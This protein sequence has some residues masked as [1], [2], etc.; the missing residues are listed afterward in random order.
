M[1][2]KMNN[3]V[4]TETTNQMFFIEKSSSRVE[5]KIDEKG[6]QIAYFQDGKCQQVNYRLLEGVRQT[7]KDLVKA[8]YSRTEDKRKVKVFP[9]AREQ[10]NWT[11]KPFVP[12]SERYEYY[13]DRIDTL[14]EE[15]WTS[16]QDSVASRQHDTSELWGEGVAVEEF[17]WLDDKSVAVQTWDLE[18]RMEWIRLAVKDSHMLLKKAEEDEDI[19]DREYKSISKKLENFRK[20]IWKDLIEVNSDLN[21]ETRILLREEEKDLEFKS[22]SP[23]SWE[24]GA[25]LLDYLEKK[26]SEM[27]A[28]E[29]IRW[30]IQVNERRKLE[31]PEMRDY[32]LSF[33]HWVACKLALEGAL[34]KIY[35]EG[36]RAQVRAE[37]SY[38]KYVDMYY[39]YNVGPRV[40]EDATCEFNDELIDPEAAYFGRPGVMTNR[41]ATIIDMKNR[42]CADETIL[43]GYILACEDALPEGTKNVDV[44]VAVLALM[45]AEGN[46]AKAARMVKMPYST[47]R[48]RLKKA[49]KMLE[50]KLDRNELSSSEYNAFRRLIG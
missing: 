29:L 27:T 32:R 10:D 35:P 23:T 6:G 14:W 8:G 20:K 18:Q 46:Q 42:L 25:N 45:K 37:E 11:Y 47:F 43:Q 7:F 31:E 5:F 36:T 34:M 33:V 50:E 17:R 3:T 9:P 30:N 49:R 38:N 44:A 19:S 13:A 28:K 48:D 26:A 24:R 21:E 15:R 39:Q 1:T 2:K 40:S 12:D 41:Y 4:A 22:K 16:R